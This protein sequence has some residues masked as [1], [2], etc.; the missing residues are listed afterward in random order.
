MAN[1]RGKKYQESKKAV[2]AGEAYSVADA[3]KLV[4]D[5]KYANF[6]ESV[7]IHF[8]LGVDIKDSDQRIRF[9][10]TL[11]SGTG[12][13][14]SVLAIDKD[15]KDNIDNIASGK[16]KPGKDFDIVIA[17]PDVMKDLAKIARIL[18][19][20]GMMPSPKNGTIAKDVES[21]KKEFSKGQIELKTQSGHA[22]LHQL[23]GSVKMSN[24]ELVGNIE[25]IVE[26]LK[27]NRPAKVKGKF[28]KKAVICTTMGPAALLD[29]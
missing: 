18:G 27:K 26:E 13:T 29:I 15:S 2:K 28:I 6:N 25:Y 22:V 24:E 4:K 9:T 21:A 19:P 5:A 7:E 11:P 3:V 10:T 12:K 1:K 17:T 23:I 16:L 20:K 14:V 8:N